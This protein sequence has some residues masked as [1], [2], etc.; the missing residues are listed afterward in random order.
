MVTPRLGLLPKDVVICVHRGSRR[1]VPA[2]SRTH[3]GR[4][5]IGIFWGICPCISAPRS[6]CATCPSVYLP[7]VRGV[8]VSC[9]GRGSY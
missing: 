2:L 3:T 7:V 8:S 6:C 4:E 1:P 5:G 9:A